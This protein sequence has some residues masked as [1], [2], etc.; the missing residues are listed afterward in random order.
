MFKMVLSSADL[1]FLIINILITLCSVS[2][3][4]REAALTHTAVGL[5]YKMLRV[6]N[7]TRIIWL[8][9]IFFYYI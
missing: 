7:L 5:F 8:M 3:D 6:T 9:L 1:L 2:S 4:Q